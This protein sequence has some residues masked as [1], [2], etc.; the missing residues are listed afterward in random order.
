[1]KEKAEMVLGLKVHA[2][3]DIAMKCSEPDVYR[4]GHVRVIFSIPEQYCKLLLERH[5]I[6]PLH[7]AY[8]EWF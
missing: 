8:V 7:L 3:H 4:I 5:T 2:S 6:V 1:M